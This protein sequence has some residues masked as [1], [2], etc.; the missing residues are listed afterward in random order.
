MCSVCVKADA[1]FWKVDLGSTQ[2]AEVSP[3]CLMTD[4]DQGS[5]GFSCC[6][7]RAHFIGKGGV[8]PQ[9]ELQVQDSWL[10]FAGMWPGK[11]LQYVC[12]RGQ[13]NF[14]FMCML[15][16]CFTLVDVFDS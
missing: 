14:I 2:G 5:V 13:H 4:G 16:M 11:G 9:A 10:P 8:L 12:V 1:L 6:P 15:N 7:P 3:P